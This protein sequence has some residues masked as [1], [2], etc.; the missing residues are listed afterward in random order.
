MIVWIYFHLNFRGGLRAN[1]R[2]PKD[3][4]CFETECVMALQDYLTSLIF[5]SIESAYATSYWSSTV[6]LV[7]FCPVSELLQVF[8]WKQHPPLSHSNFTDLTRLSMLGLLR[9]KDA[10]IIICVITFELTQYITP[11]YQ[12]HGQ[13]DRRTDGRRPIAIPR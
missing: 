1:R 4:S 8:C 2:A 9:S 10:K 3:A 6:T 12:R 13:T 5:A 7:L 11:K